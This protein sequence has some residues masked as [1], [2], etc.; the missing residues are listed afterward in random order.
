MLKAPAATTTLLSIPSPRKL[1][2]AHLHRSAESHYCEA[3]LIC[4]RISRLN[5][6]R[7]AFTMCDT[8]VDAKHGRTFEITSNVP[9]ANDFRVVDRLMWSRGAE[10]REPL[11]MPSLSTT[12]N[13]FA[14]TVHEKR[15]EMTV[16][17]SRYGGICV[18]GVAVVCKFEEERRIVLTVAAAYT[19][20]DTSI[21]IR[22]TGW[23]VVSKASSK[24]E[25]PG[26]AATL[27]QTHRRIHS[28][29]KEQPN[30]S[31]GADEKTQHVEEVV[32]RA[33]DDHQRAHMAELQ[34][35]LLSTPE[36]MALNL[37][38]F[39]CPVTECTC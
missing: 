34:R 11:T 23:I 26:S 24:S 15:V 7:M 31:L 13:Q 16:S 27:F 19:V 38:E 3:D 35:S 30:L 33:L 28:E 5:D 9:V 8:K 10:N 2:L 21:T 17:S 1:L 25:G 6:T 12:A 14:H 32:L 36:S 4:Q 22:E 29:S 18:D 39:K 37:M 20:S